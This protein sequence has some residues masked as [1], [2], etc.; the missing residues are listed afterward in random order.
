MECV[1]SMFK[2]SIIATLKI[3]SDFDILQQ[4]FK[5]MLFQN[6]SQTKNYNYKLTFCRNLRHK[7]RMNTHS[8]RI[9]CMF[10]YR[11]SYCS[12]EKVIFMLIPPTVQ[13]RN[14][15]IK[16]NIKQLFISCIRRTCHTGRKENYGA[17]QWFLSTNCSVSRNA[18][19]EFA[20]MF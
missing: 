14:V 19:T 16:R 17:K 8:L 20:A 4:R 2:S 10:K 1:I 3:A 15:A 5:Q 7:S 12:S 13:L 9:S 11:N 6:G 18:V